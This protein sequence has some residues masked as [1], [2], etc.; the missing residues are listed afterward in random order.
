MGEYEYELCLH[1][2]FHTGAIA[3]D[4]WD[5]QRTDDLVHAIDKH[6]SRKG[7]PAFT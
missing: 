4:A 2:R 3:M 7:D 5:H 6:P 1:P